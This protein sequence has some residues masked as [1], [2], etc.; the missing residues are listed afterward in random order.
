MSHS[1]YRPCNYLVGVAL[2]VGLGVTR[3]AAAA[4]TVCP[5][6]CPYTSIQAA[7]DAAP[8]GETIR[9][10]EGVFLGAVS[11]TDKSLILRGSGPSY[12]VIDRGPVAVSP[13]PPAIGLT[14][15][16]ASQIT[17]V[18]LTI[19]GGVPYHGFG[20]RGLENA[21]CAVNV[22]NVLVIHNGGRGAGGIYNSGT[23]TVRNST[24]VNNGAELDG[25]GITNAGDLTL[26]GSLVGDNVTTGK[27]GGVNNGGTLVVRY[28]TIA[29]NR[30]PDGG[31]FANAV[32]GQARFVETVFAHN[33]TTSPVGEGGG[34]WNVGSMT[35]R[36]TL[37]IANEAGEI[38]GGIYTKASG[39]TVL[40]GSTVMNNTSGTSGGGLYSDGAMTVISS[41]ITGNT[42]DNC[43]GAGYACP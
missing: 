2:L 39:T 7:V 42:P 22:N 10:M 29:G 30:A 37:V 13:A 5:S 9:I 31:G 43:A 15:S 4:I 11:I 8:S 34:L 19:T 12:T 25:G 1:G 32:G 21:G 26:V 14:C 24:I 16:G 36:N 3:T 17:I 41:L 18:D 38:G 28:S 35:L 20:G 33:T 23:M 6:G 40:N 27:G